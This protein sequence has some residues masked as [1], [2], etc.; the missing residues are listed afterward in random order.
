MRFQYGLRDLFTLI[1]QAAVFLGVL[2]S[3]LLTGIVR[4][5]CFLAEPG[6]P[7]GWLLYG[8]PL[9]FYG[10]HAILV[11]IGF[12]ICIALGLRSPRRGNLPRMWVGWLII[13]A[14]VAFFVV[15]LVL[16]PK[17]VVRRFFSCQCVVQWL[18]PTWYA[19][20]NGI[21]KRDRKTNRK[22]G[23]ENVSGT[24]DLNYAGR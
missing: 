13:I 17:G 6:P 20:E 7:E 24:I 1:L 4:Y 3:A 15:A 14:L 22:T 18:L 11:G 5:N 9:D 10:W 21:G 23:S 19:S 8:L 2:T 12:A 16:H